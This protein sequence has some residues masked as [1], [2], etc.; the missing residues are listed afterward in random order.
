MFPLRIDSGDD[1]YNYWKAAAGK[2][3]KE[4]LGVLPDP[5]HDSHMQVYRITRKSPFQI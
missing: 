1:E 5:L 2:A 3:M 4:R